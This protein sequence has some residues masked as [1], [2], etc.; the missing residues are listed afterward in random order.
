[1]DWVRQGVSH[2]IEGSVLAFLT[3]EEVELRAC[4]TKDIST[5]ALKAI[6]VYNVG[7]DN[8]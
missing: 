2:V 5:E 1:M 3:W 7:E 4:G 8:K 6:S